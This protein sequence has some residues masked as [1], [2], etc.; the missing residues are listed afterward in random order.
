MVAYPT[1]VAAYDAAIAAGVKDVD[2]V[3]R[4]NEAV[5]RAQGSG[6]VMDV[7]KVLRRRGFIK[8]F[9]PFMTFALNDFNRKKYY[10]AGFVEYARGGHSNIDFKTYA[11]HLALEWIAPVVFSSMMLSLGRDGELPDA[12]DYFWEAMGFYLMGVPVVRDVIRSAEVQFT[13]KGYGR[14]VGG[15]VAF[16][17]LESGIKAAQAG[18][19]ALLEDD[20]RAA[21]RFQREMINT[22]GFMIGVGTPQLWRTMDGVEAFFVD[23]EGG[24]LAPFLGKPQKKKD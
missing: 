18:S 6:G 4:G 24:V 15:S 11:Q 14:G 20:E 12:E 9:T 5:I 1:W 3:Q 21:K 16:A 7:S 19:K 13:G 10:T 23:D 2:A 17:G 22:M 8:L